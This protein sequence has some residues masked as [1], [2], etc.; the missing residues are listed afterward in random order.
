MKSHNKECPW[1]IAPNHQQPT[2][3]KKKN[4]LVTH[5]EYHILWLRLRCYFVV[6]CVMMMMMMVPL[7]GKWI[8]IIIESCF[9]LDFRYC[10]CVI[11]LPSYPSLHVLI[12]ASAVDV[13]SWYFRLDTMFLLIL[14]CLPFALPHHW[15][16][17]WHCYYEKPTISISCFANFLKQISNLKW[18]GKLLLLNNKN[19]DSS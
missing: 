16:W 19:A 2:T 18:Y 3:T 9:T 15:H 12:I 14:C 7:Q 6:S 10:W 11:S 8:K 17:H 1:N 13:F 4:N 5:I